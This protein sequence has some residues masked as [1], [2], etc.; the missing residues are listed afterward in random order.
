MNQKMTLIA[1]AF[2]ALL[3]VAGSASAGTESFSDLDADQNGTIG[4]S[5][6]RQSEALVEQWDSLDANGDNQ[7]DQGEFS[8]FEADAAD[9]TDREA[10]QVPGANTRY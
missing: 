9:K 7:L 2:A 4:A 6:A 1:P 10:Q 3:L 5:E 8:R